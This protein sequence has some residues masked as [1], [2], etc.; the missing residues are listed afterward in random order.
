MLIGVLVCT[1]FAVALAAAVAATYRFCQGVNE[2]G[3]E[4]LRMEFAEIAAKRL[5]E[6]ETDLASRNREQ[7]Q[8]LFDTLA[9]RL[10]EFRAAAEGA[11][12]TNAELGVAIKTQIGTLE[13]TAQSLGTKAEWLASALSSGTKLQGVWGETI[14][15]DVLRRSGLEEGKHYFAQKGTTS[16]PDVQVLDAQGRMMIIDAK[17]NLAD[18]IEACNA[19]GDEAKRKVHLAAHAAAL[20][21]QIKA[22]Q[23]ADYVKKLR[24]QNPE[25]EYLDVV[26]LFI[27]SEGAYAAALAEKPA[28]WQ[29]A[30]D[31]NILLISPQT[32]LAYMAIVSIAWRQSAA[33]KNQLEIAKQ[34]EILLKYVNTFLVNIDILGQSLE[35]AQADYAAARKFLLDA[36]REH[37]IVRPARR[38][39]ELG[40]RLEERNAKKISPALAGEG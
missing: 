28:L 32:L 8:P 18:Y 30:N 5:A 23:G 6:R 13:R 9:L 11:Q 20:E 4:A 2:R 7:V 3:I 33:E 21:R 15:E 22:L 25:Q 40:I 36:S 14:L 29:I 16:R 27:P 31:A 37:N 19:G 39:M 1:A 17:T 24:A 12:K 26:G 34:G 10:A 35:K 38:L